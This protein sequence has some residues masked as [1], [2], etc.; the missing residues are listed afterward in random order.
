M[1]GPFVRRNILFAVIDVTLASLEIGSFAAQRLFAV[2]D[3]TNPREQIAFARRK[4]NIGLT[5]TNTGTQGRVLGRGAGRHIER[6]DKRRV[7]DLLQRDDHRRHRQRVSG[8]FD[9]ARG[10]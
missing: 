2:V 7:E 3:L 5:P 8:E 6:R 1:C 9:F 4:R 10:S